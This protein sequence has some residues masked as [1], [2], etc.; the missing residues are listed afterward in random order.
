MTLAMPH[1]SLAGWPQLTIGLSPPILAEPLEV[2]KRE[3][4]DV[5]GGVGQ[6]ADREELLPEL[7][8]PGAGRLTTLPAAAV[9]FAP[10]FE[11]D[12]EGRK[13]LV[14]ERLPPSSSTKTS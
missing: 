13:A 9:S 11:E 5:V 12:T 3:G 1:G 6:S 14:E 4:L 2:A 8:E 10:Y 7:G